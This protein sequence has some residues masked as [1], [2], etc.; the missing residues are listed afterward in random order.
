MAVIVGSFPAGLASRSDRLARVS[1]R[2]P[3]NKFPL[4][5]KK[6]AEMMPERLA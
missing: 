6:R 5:A 4:K 3:E 1:S 2:H